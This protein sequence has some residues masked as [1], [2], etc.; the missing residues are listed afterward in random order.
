MI[1]SQ[2]VIDRI[3]SEKPDLFK[4]LAL[5]A[6]FVGAKG[7]IAVTPTAWV[8]P[9]GKRA[10]DPINEV[11]PMHQRVRQAFT[12][13]IGFARAGAEGGGRI[14][15]FEDVEEQLIDALLGW[16]PEGAVDP[17]VFSGSDL[18]GWEPD[19]QTIFYGCNFA[20]GSDV[21]K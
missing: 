3:K 8:L 16:Q 6:D 2:T 13:I 12:I 21:R 17:F 1:T 14:D 10:G 5:A 20:A 9:S 19:K 11:G 18:I 4:K 15:E 7:Q